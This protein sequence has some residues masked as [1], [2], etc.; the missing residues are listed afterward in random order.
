[1]D[2]SAIS[3]GYGFNLLCHLASGLL[4]YSF[5]T[6]DG[7]SAD[8]GEALTRVEEDQVLLEHWTRL[9]AHC[10]WENMPP[11]RAGWLL[12]ISRFPQEQHDLLRSMELFAVAHEYTHHA[13]SHT[14]SDTSAIGRD[15]NLDEEEADVGGYLISRRLTPLVANPF[16]H[17][18]T[19]AAAVLCVLDIIRK[20]EFALLH[21]E[22]EPPPRG[23]HPPTRERLALLDAVDAQEG[24]E[25]SKAYRDAFAKFFDLLWEALKPA[26]L[27]LG[28]SGLLPKRPD[29]DG[30]GGS[31]LPG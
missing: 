24:D 23:D 10:A 1:L 27:E 11:P 15:P 3:V 20:A 8:A 5:A 31:W 22:G 9:V 25:A 4:I 26:M 29:G 17:S 2:I 12:S 6:S 16:A 30:D 28:A 19:G 7:F 21:G 14:V 18:G 13:L